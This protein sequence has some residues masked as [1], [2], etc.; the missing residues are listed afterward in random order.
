M[1][2]SLTCKAS[3]VS[4]K[5]K[6]GGTEILLSGRNCTL[7]SNCTHYCSQC[8]KHLP[9]LPPSSLHPILHPPP[10]SLPASLMRS[11]WFWI[12]CSLLA[13]CGWHWGRCSCWTLIRL[14]C[15]G[16]EWK[17]NKTLS[18][19]EICTRLTFHRLCDMYS[20][21]SSSKRSDVGANALFKGWGGKPSE[22]GSGDNWSVTCI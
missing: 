4:P 16:T 7:L 9:S 17:Q 14:S 20:D 21:W 6:A 19:A 1:N 18:S 3:F 15:N 12:S 2:L 13:L 10:S 8:S 22:S 11:H 5:V